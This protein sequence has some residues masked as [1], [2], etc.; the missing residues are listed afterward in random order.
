MIQRL[1]APEAAASKEGSVDLSLPQYAKKVRCYVD[2]RKAQGRR[3]AK[4]K[5]GMVC[6][7]EGGICDEIYLL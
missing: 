4:K 7:R 5:Y 1:R 3:A 6:R 2:K